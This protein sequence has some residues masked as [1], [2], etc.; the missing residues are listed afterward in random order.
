MKTPEP[1]SPQT[2]RNQNLSLLL[3]AL[4]RRDEVTR[5][6]LEQETAL[7][8]ATVWRLVDDLRD[9]GAVV[10]E[11]SEPVDPSARGR[12]PGSLRATRALGASAGLS[13]GLRSSRVLVTDL[14]G[15]ELAQEQLQTPTW[16]DLGDA[17]DWAAGVVAA[18]LEGVH[19]RLRRLVVAV[20][21][22]AI[23]GQVVARLPLFMGVIEGPEF[24]RLLA[25]R[26]G[27]PVRIE[28]D[29]A[30]ILAGLEALGLLDREAFP[31]LLNFGS[32]LTMS[33]RRA[34]G[35]IAE[36]RS[37]S[38]GDFSLI[39]VETELGRLRIGDLLGAHGLFEASR[40]LGRGLPAMEDLWQTDSEEVKRLGRAFA[41]ALEHA[42]RAIVVMS[43]PSEIVFTGRLAPLVER[44]L[45][46]VERHL[47]DEVAEPPRL[48]VVD[49]TE[50]AHAAAVGAAE[51]AR[52][53]ATIELL[54]RVARQ[55]VEALR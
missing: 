36:G 45:A 47:A 25:E 28:T 50:E 41:V 32:V 24:G 8:K 27:C 15:T 9:V 53:G 26:L 11:T 51:E 16:R 42:L 5:K 46:E 31:V 48:R 17:V 14:H 38:F 4:L 39:P 30:M 6:Q 19:P 10:M 3:R 20:P 13:L 44:S 49:Y 34:D 2:L 22:R 54:D 52:W 37:S 23:N 12:R 33:L 43:D 7:S 35:T 29:A 1:L 21:A 40:R 18:A 55:G